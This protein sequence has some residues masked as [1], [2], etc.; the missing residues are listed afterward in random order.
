[1]FA[2]GANPWIWESPVTTDTVTRLG[3][4]LA[5]WGLDPIEL[6]VENLGDWDP[7]VVR[8]TLA[9]FGLS[10]AAVIA[11]TSPGRELVQT[12]AETVAHT[13]DYIRACADLAVAV[14]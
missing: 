2:I 12:S 8:E 11:V 9:V 6:P 5:D 13:Q 14:G 4:K 3:P 7:D 10:A 1:M